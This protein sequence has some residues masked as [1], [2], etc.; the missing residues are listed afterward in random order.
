MNVLKNELIQSN[1]QNTPQTNDTMKSLAQFLLRSAQYTTPRDFAL[2]Q[3]FVNQ[4]TETMS[5]TEARHLQNLLRLCQNNM[6]MT[7]QQAAVQQKLPDLP[8]LWA[9][10]QMCDM[11]RISS[12]MNAKA[13]KRAG[14]DVADFAMS[15]RRAMTADNSVIQNQRSFQM[16][17]PIYLGDNTASYPTY[18]SVYDE[19]ER[20]EETGENRKA[21]W[22]RICVLTDHIGAAE[23]VFR[24]YNETELDLRFYFSRRDIAEEFRGIYLEDLK[25]SINQSSALSV[26]EV[27]VGGGSERMFS[28]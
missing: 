14:R 10:M 22:L 6:P 28:F 25:D 1:W 17:M 13:F 18:L 23:L 12:G 26:G 27:R 7:V 19:N 16:M 5:E 3:N 2:L 8:R 20:D 21:T 11:A 9:F 4:S 24:I 15:M